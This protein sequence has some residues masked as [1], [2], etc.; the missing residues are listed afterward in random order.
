MTKKHMKDYL[1][2][3]C[4]YGHFE[5]FKELGFDIEQIGVLAQNS[6]GFITEEDIIETRKRLESIVKEIQST[7]NEV[8]CDI[9]LY[10]VLEKDIEN[11]KGGEHISL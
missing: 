3:D 11:N 4:R 9:N 8:V 7:F 1:D 6:Y 5:N 10:K 2:S